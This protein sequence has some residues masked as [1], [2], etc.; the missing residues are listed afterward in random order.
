MASCC[1]P[2]FVLTTWMGPGEGKTVAD[3]E[4]PVAQTETLALQARQ[5]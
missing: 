3:A 1:Q 2:P 4:S 5:A